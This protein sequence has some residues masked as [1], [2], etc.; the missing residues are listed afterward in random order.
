MDKREELCADRI[1]KP[2]RTMTDASIADY[3]GSNRSDTCLDVFAYIP[4]ADAS[5]HSQ[6]K[7]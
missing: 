3:L 4:A 7:C 5:L 6:P 1:Y 2:A